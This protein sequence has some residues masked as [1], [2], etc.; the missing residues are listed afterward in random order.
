MVAAYEICASELVA[1]NK[2][3]G[4][5]RLLLLVMVEA[6]AAH[7]F[8]QLY[9]MFISNLLEFYLSLVLMNPCQE[10]PLEQGGACG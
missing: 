6:H 8:E 3:T 10:H 2:S 7:P 4:T 1:E 9:L 5:L